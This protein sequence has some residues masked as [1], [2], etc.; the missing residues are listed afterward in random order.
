M[1][2]IKYFVSDSY[3]DWTDGRM[4]DDYSEADAYAQE[5]GC[6]V[7]AVTFEF[8]DSEPVRDYSDDTE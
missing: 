5:H 2:I 8:S 7:T 6:C 4:F 3:D 1:D